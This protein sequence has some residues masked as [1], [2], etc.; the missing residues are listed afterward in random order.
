MIFEVIK[1]IFSKDFRETVSDLYKLRKTNDWKKDIQ[2]YKGKFRE[3]LKEEA[4]LLIDDCVK[5]LVE[6]KWMEKDIQNIR[7]VFWELV[8]NAFTYGSKV[9]S[10]KLIFSQ[11]FIRFEV[12]DSGKGFNLNEVLKK[13]GALENSSYKSVRGLGMICRIT[14]AI[15][16]EKKWNLHTLKVLLLKGEGS[17]EVK[18]YMGITIFIV[19]GMTYDNE[20]FWRELENRLNDLPENSKVLISFLTISTNEVMQNVELKPNRSTAAIHIMLKLLQEKRDSFK[21]AMYGLNSISYEIG[22]YIKFHFNSF[23]NFDEAVKFLN[24]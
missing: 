19:N 18:S 11:S 17:I 15:S 3:E 7:F 2:I 16:N 21:I 23:D 13:Q 22:K 5:I 20:I 9:V 1:L 24:E 10:V 14:P 8:N 4:K 6:K 12:S